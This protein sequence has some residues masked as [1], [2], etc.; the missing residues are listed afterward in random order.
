MAARVTHSQPTGFGPRDILV[1][2]MMNILWGLNIVA[3]KLAVEATG[4]FTAAMLRQAIVFIV[5]ASALRI[6]PGKMRE[7]IGL[8]FLSGGVFYVFVNWSLA[9]SDNVSA[10]AIAGQLSVPFSLILAVIF[11]GERIH[12]VRIG[13]IA[14]SFLGVVLLV[15]DPSA[16]SEVTGIALTAA[17]SFIWA[18]ASL[19]QRRM[20]GVPVLTIY[21]WMGLIGTIVLLPLTIW[22][23]GD[24]LKA[25]PT[26]PLRD[27]GWIAFS[28]IGSTICGHGAMS[29]LLQRH[30]ITSVV[31]LML[32]SPVISVIA[33]SLF[34]ATPLTPIMIA[35][36]SIALVGVAIVTIRTA[37][38]KEHQG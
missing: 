31:P 13:G 9:V 35:G 17:G 26:L 34:F 4:P 32:A 14:L 1:A 19:I 10:L 23:E 20:A 21:A 15:F 3:V 12:I 33:A 6:V 37:R 38:A 2:A 5:C 27:F 22:Q 7:L 36:G 18:L 24:V 16:G 29:W 30:P 8:G 25:L 11:L 28:A